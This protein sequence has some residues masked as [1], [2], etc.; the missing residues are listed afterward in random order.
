MKAKPNSLLDKVVNQLSSSSATA[1]NSTSAAST[2]QSAAAAISKYANY[3]TATAAQAVKAA[4]ANANTVPMG[5][6]TAGI[7][8]NP[9]GGAGARSTPI[10]PHLTIMPTNGNGPGGS[11]L[12]SPLLAGSNGGAASGVGMKRTDS[13]RAVDRDST[14]PPSEAELSST[15]GVLTLA[16][17]ERMLRW[18]AEAVGRVVQLSQ[19]DV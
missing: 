18:H 16:A 13:L 9:G 3:F 11:G 15:D 10:P 2:A 8:G 5:A 14:G 4:A 19:S 1:S 17:A 7:V 6:A 12:S